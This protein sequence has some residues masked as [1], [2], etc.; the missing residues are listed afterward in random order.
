MGELTRRR[1]LV[2][3]C[4]G[5][6]QR[7]D[8]WFQIRRLWFHLKSTCRQNNYQSKQQSELGAQVILD[9]LAQNSLNK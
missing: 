4:L 3:A 7:A 9:I 5:M 2:R 6:E 8:F 1:A